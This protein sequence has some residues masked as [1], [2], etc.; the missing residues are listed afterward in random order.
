[1]A[2]ILMSWMATQ[3]DFVGEKVNLNGP[4]MQM[5][6]YYYNYDQHIY[7]HT[8][9]KKKDAKKIQKTIITKFER[10]IFLQEVDVSKVHEDLYVIK[11]K[12]EQLLMEHLEDEIDIL[13]STG[14]G[15]MKIAWYICHTTL[16]LNT[17]IIQI[18]PPGFEQNK[19]KPGLVEITT[20]TST[21]P[22]SAMIVQNRVEN[23]PKHQPFVTSSLKDVYEKA[24]KVAQTDKVSV[25]LLGDTGTGKE[26]L[27]RYIHDNS[28]RKNKPFRA[29]NCSAFTET[30]LESRLFGHKKGS[31]TDAQSD[32]KGIFEEADGGTVFLD[33]IGD[34][35]PY[36]QQSLLRF[37]QFKE[38][39]PVGGKP[40]KV[41]VRII[42]ATNKN[43]VQLMQQATFRSDLFYRLGII[44]HIPKFASFDLSEKKQWIE[45]FMKTKQKEFRRVETITLNDELKG[46]LLQ[47][48][49]PG[50]FRELINIIDNLYVFSSSIATMNDLP[51]YLSLIESKS[52]LKLK[53]VTQNHI[54]TVLNICNGN[55]SKATKLLGISLNTLKKYINQDDEDYY[56]DEFD[57]KNEND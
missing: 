35:S 44:L 8:P 9:D 30:V 47:Y 48:H 40:K 22:Y 39:Q 10:E 21:V 54:Q 28:S 1:M 15:I 52:N 36:M 51:Q 27:A 31:F 7:L 25:L 37:L 53:N 16:S 13:L 2:K 3:N 43:V 14:S 34:I 45:H 55:K 33:E 6:T 18:M 20:E 42:A 26:E 29:F 24:Q 49:F 38:I 23:K 4:T 19:E 56:N 50:N 12:I 46:F 17:R 5:H 32:F 41:D 11:S 57:D